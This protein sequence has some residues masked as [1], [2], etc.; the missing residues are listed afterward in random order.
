MAGL[1][2][3]FKRYL[4]ILASVVFIIAV[5]TSIL[6]CLICMFPKIAGKFMALH[7]IQFYQDFGAL[8]LSC[9]LALYDRL[10]VRR[11][12]REERSLG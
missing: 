7:L 9:F 11:L 1:A 3:W 2:P 8:A 10:L 4:M 5:T 6:I 12:G